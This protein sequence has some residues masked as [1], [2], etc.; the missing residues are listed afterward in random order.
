MTETSR[1]VFLLFIAALIG[2]IVGETTGI[3]VA[4]DGGSISQCFMAGGGAFAGSVAL[5]LGV[6]HA[7]KVL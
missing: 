2:V 1:R 7:L 6:F 4:I 5:F 3:L